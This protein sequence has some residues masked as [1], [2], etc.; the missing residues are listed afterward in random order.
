MVNIVK[1]KN[2]TI[3][4]EGWSAIANITS[5]FALLFASAE[6]LSVAPLILAG[7]SITLPFIAIPLVIASVFIV[8]GIGLKYY[9]NGGNLGKAIYDGLTS[10]VLN[11][12]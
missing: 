1:L 11:F 5:E 8:V 4:D 10:M 12:I 6:I 9:G 7:V 3:S 2:F